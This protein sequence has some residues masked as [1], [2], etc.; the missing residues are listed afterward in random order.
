[1]QELRFKR[2]SDYKER[3][4]KHFT[5]R[6]AIQ[7]EQILRLEEELLSWQKNLDGSFGFKDVPI[8]D[9]PVQQSAK[10]ISKPSSPVTRSTEVQTDKEVVKSEH[11]VSDETH[12]KQELMNI[13]QELVNKNQNID[14]MKNKI[15]ELEVSMNTYKT[16]IGDKQSQISFYE[17]HIIDLQNKKE[18]F[19]SSNV[20]G[21]GGDNINIGMETTNVTNNEELIAL[22]VSIIK[23]L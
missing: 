2:Q 7:D 14:H 21:A 17:R 6:I 12:L 9:L 13:K 8:R 22:R 11:D 3:Q 23:F 4:L 15:Q 16:Q 10:P 20:N 19:H 18:D 5:E 1:M